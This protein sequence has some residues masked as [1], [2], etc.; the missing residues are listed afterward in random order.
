MTDTSAEIEEVNGTANEEIRSSSEFPASANRVWD[1]A[2]ALKHCVCLFFR[3]LSPLILD[4]VL[5]M[6]EFWHSFFWVEFK[7]VA[8]ID[9]ACSLLKKTIQ[10]SGG[11]TLIVKSY[12]PSIFTQIRASSGV[13]EQDFQSEWDPAAIAEKV[14]SKGAGKSGSLF[15]SSKTG[16]YL[17]KTLRKEEKD[18]LKKMARELAYVRPNH[19]IFWLT[20]LY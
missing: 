17:L 13:S 11:R 15:V 2:H 9:E 18:A 6:A 20:A 16:K 10:A 19:E 7:Q 5:T 8:P 1:F 12:Q 4:V 14:A 3:S